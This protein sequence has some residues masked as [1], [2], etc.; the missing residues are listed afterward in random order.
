MA[1][2]SPIS[3]PKLT[4]LPGTGRIEAFSDGV[5]AIVITLMVLEI[6]LP[7]LPEGVTDAQ[8]LLALAPVLPK[9]LAYALSFVMVGIFW[10]NHHQFFHALAKADAPLLWWNNLFLFWLCLIPFPTAFVGEHPGLKTAAASF[11]LVMLLGAGSFY[12][13][14]R[15]AFGAAAL[16]LPGLRAADMRRSVRRSAVGPVV[17]ALALALV[18]V[19]VYA[20]FALF[21]LVPLWFF[22]PFL[23]PFSKQNQDT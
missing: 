19:S 8:A 16:Y 4:E 12:A 15:H 11:A 18:W 3:E 2:P 20:A 21:V 9:L 22:F 6:K 13:M 5:I 23:V 10:V 7:E 14:R 1:S 17:Y